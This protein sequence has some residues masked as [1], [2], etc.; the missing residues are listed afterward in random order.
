MLA[1]DANPTT[2]ILLAGLV[3]P[4][5]TSNEEIQQY[6][7]RVMQNLT[8]VLAAA[9]SGFDRVVKTTCFLADLAL[10]EGRELEATEVT[11][12]G[13]QESRSGR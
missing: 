3:P 10:G 11:S 12:V 9:G 4:V 8:A 2:R 13:G 5:Y 7:A 1:F 6:R